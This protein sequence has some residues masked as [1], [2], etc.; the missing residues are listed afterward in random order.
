M[1]ALDKLRSIKTNSLNPLDQY[2][3]AEQEQMFDYLDQ[4]EYD[5]LQEKRQNDDFI[6]DDEGYGYKDKGGEIW[7]YNEDE[8]GGG[9]RK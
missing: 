7:E 1:D 8:N 6:V 2:Q 4:E 5:K 3:V 9:N